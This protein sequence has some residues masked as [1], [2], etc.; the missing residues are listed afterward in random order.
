MA[1]KLESQ[2]MEDGAEI[3]HRDNTRF[4]FLYPNGKPELPA[5]LKGT[6]RVQTTYELAKNR[7]ISTA[8]NM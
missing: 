6:L 1:Q 3:I 7:K 5:G 2:V 4:Q 8:K